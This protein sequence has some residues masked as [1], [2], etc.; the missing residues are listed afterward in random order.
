MKKTIL[1]LLIIISLVSCNKYSREKYPQFATKTESYKYVNSCY[2]AEFDNIN[3]IPIDIQ[4]QF[5]SYLKNRLGKNDFQKLEFKNGYALSDEPIDIERT[6]SESEFLAIL[7]QNKEKSNCD[8]IIDFPVYSM[9][10][11]LKLP[12]I[13]IEKLGLNLMLDT[14][15]KTIKDIDFPKAEFRDKLIPIDSVHSELIRRKIP[16]KKLNIDLWFD[17][18]TESFVWSTSTLIREGSI[19]GPSCFPEVKYH[20]KMNANNGEITE[21]NN[22]QTNDYF[23]GSDNQYVE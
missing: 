3:K 11:E 21:F 16:Y 9:I 20:F 14:N 6:N 5:T 8:S 4:N 7:G 10:Y 1:S 12:E 22:V 18:R 17:K 15:G 19:M 2:S 23:F 13:G